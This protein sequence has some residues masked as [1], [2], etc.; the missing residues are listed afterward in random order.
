MSALTRF[1]FVSQVRVSAAQAGT[2]ASNAM[3]SHKAARNR[4][5]PPGPQRT[6]PRQ[7]RFNANRPT[8]PGVPDCAPNHRW[9]KII[10]LA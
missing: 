6:P 1:R 4:S 7:A 8:L 9:I 2:V 10:M 5:E 3:A